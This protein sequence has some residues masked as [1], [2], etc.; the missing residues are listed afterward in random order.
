MVTTPT[1]LV[2][3]AGPV[4]LVAAAEL[5]RR[6]VS[7][8]IIDKLAAPV[9][10]SRALAVHAR[11]LDM[12]AQMGVV[13][14]LIET[15]VKCGGMELYS[16]RHQLFRLPL[17][18]VDAAYPFS[19]NTP[20][21]ETERVLTAHLA[22]LGVAVE[23]GVELTALTQDSAEVRATLQHS[24][25]TAE[26]ATAGWVIGADGARS[27]VRHLVG[28]KLE[29]TFVGEHL[30]LGDVLVDH[31]A[32]HPLDATT[33]Y[34]FFAPAGPVLVLPFRGGRA[35]V[36]AQIHP[37]D[38]LDQENLLAELQKIVDARVGGITL[39]QPHWLTTFELRHA[40]VRQYRHSRVFLAGDAAHIH[41]PAGGQGMNT[42]MQDAFNLAWKL[43]SVIA[44]HAG[45]GLLDSYQ[46]ERRPI[47]ESVIAFSNRLSKA[48]TL[49][50]AA[51]HVRNALLRVAS[52]IRPL[53]RAMADIAAEITVGYPHSPLAVGHAPRGA[54]VAAGAHFPYL[55]ETDVQHQLSRT[56]DTVHTTVTVAASDIP[57]PGT[58]GR[59]VLITDTDA[60]VA[61]YD[62]VIADPKQ[63]AA[64]RLG[65]DSGGR[66]V[67][68][69]DGYVGTVTTVD[70]HHT[71]DEY[72][73]A[74]A[75]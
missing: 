61:G 36:M 42:G 66:V 16:G 57:A 69:P 14:E 22:S 41:S 33:M 1:V 71:I 28:D 4:G 23:R 72:F 25:G 51:Q 21:S 18:S 47:A 75:R 38:S 35:R 63:V 73:A 6:G 2:V 45:D 31:D 74:V 50:G 46:A 34:T 10:E 7:V 44:G 62:V 64:Q 67:V 8:R 5:A 43:A 11:S 26:E 12:L 24:D 3:G 39:S 49:R 70:D 40:L 15:G 56:F 29:G 17:D 53:P 52:H 37:D 9:P 13:D 48:G 20:Q 19:L 65:L 55:G 59:Q 58:V 60:P 54:K 32:E 30:L 27:A 68:R